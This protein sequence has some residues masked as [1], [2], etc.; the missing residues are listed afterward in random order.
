MSA[1]ALSVTSVAAASPTKAS[2]AQ[3]PAPTDAPTAGPTP[4]P[5]TGPTVRPL[6]P[7]TNSPTAAPTARPSTP[8]TPKPSLPPTPS[9]TVP[10]TPAPTAP[11]TMAPTPL[12][13]AAPTAPPTP[14]PTA[15][16]T[17]APTA[18]PSLPPTDPPTVGPTPL[19]G[20]LSSLTQAPSAPVSTAVVVCGT[21]PG[22]PWQTIY[23]SDDTPMWFRL[24]DGEPLAFGLRFAAYRPGV[25]RAVRFY[26]ALG[27]A[28]IGH[29]GRI[30]GG[31]SGQLLAST[32]SNVVD[33]RC[34]GPQWVSLYL[35]SPLNVTA[36]TEYV[37]GLPSLFFLVLR[38]CELADGSGGCVAGRGGQRDHVRQ[39]GEE[40]GRGTHQRR[41]DRPHERS[42]FW[43]AGECTQRGALGG[44]GQLLH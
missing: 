17:D 24:T 5:T 39:V 22:R 32:G 35:S 23:N 11:P 43:A 15:Q 19:L 3:T 25:V 8:P 9:P 4:P 1:S 31:K 33:T 29:S 18:R 30:Y 44:R 13:T 27:E 34:P 2:A 21:F 37:V 40:P 36:N 42:R 10:P 7:P 20:R 12:P 41:P 6:L 14:A 38:L 26:K 16:P 28:G